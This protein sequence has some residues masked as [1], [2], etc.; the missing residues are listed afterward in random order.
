M[1]GKTKNLDYS[2]VPTT[3]ELE[4][5]GNQSKYTVNRKPSSGITLSKLTI[6][7]MAL[8]ALLLIALAVGLT[9]L[10]Y[11]H[12]STAAPE[13]LT[14]A[15]RPTATRLPTNLSPSH[16]RLQI[17]PFLNEKNFTT[18]GAVTITFKVKEETN[19]IVVNIYDMEIDKESVKVKHINSTEYIT[20]TD[21][22]FEDVSQIYVI[23]TQ[24]VLQNDEEY[25]L[26]IKFT[27]HLRDNMQGF[28]RSQYI[29]PK[30]N[31]N[32]YMA[33]TQFSPID[34]RRAFPCFDEPSFKAKFTISVGRPS[35]M[36]S[37]SNMPKRSTDTMY[38]DLTAYRYNNSSRTL[39]T[40]HTRMKSADQIKLAIDLSPKI[41][42][43]Y[44]NYFKIKFPLPKIDLVGV[45]DF[46]FNAMEN[47]GLITF[48]ETAILFDENSA[49]IEDKK[50]IITVLAH[51]IAHQW[52]GNLVTPAWWNDLWL[53][54]GFSNFMLYYAIQQIYPTW[55]FMDEY[56]LNENYEAFKFDYYKSSRPV[57]LE[58]VNA[59][60]IRQMFDSISY[61]KGASVI[62]MLSHIVGQEVFK[63]GLIQYLNQY[64]YSNANHDQLWTA[65]ETN[66]EDSNSLDVS[67]KEV[68]DSWILQPGFPVVTAVRNSTTGEV[69]LSQKRFLFSKEP[70]NKTLWWIPVSYASDLKP[71]LD[72]TKPKFWIRNVPEAMVV[73][74]ANHWWLLNVQQTGYYIVNYDENN[75]RRLTENIII[76]PPTTR[77]QLI[78]DSMDLARANLLDYDIPLKMLTNLA[79]Q[80]KDISF[81]THQAALNKVSFLY[82]ML[83][84]SPIFKQFEDFIYRIFNNAFNKVD[85]NDLPYDEYLV[86]RIRKLITKWACTK[87]ESKCTNTAQLLFRKWIDNPIKDKLRP[88]IQEV[89]YCTSIREG[90]ETEWDF[91]YNFYI[92]STS[93]YEKNI[94]LDSLGCSQKP[95]ILNRY[96]DYILNNNTYIRK[97]DSSRVFK[98]VANNPVGNSLA[99]SYLRRNW[100]ELNDHFGSAFSIVSKMVAELPR[101]MNNRYQLAEL[102]NFKN[103]NIDNLGTSSQALDR[104]IETVKSNIEWMDHSYKSIENWLNDQA[105]YYGLQK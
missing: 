9:I 63:Q 86:Q 23:T 92:K 73:I 13:A 99:F 4:S 72:N 95:W 12:C 105:R 2:S 50:Q 20:V 7:L 62:R 94:L 46:G 48:R 14:N 82:N 64:Q 1:V 89:V 85:F 93:I 78:S 32:R 69:H 81:V 5:N 88:N 40:V 90:G 37:I 39:F 17:I 8:G 36:S 18:S 91:L 54:E 35:N 6:V 68:M 61:S 30:T 77:V 22:Q 43:F 27:G 44:E 47:W 53:K 83:G 3:A 25:D 96:L 51:E 16:Y 33:S 104:V 11:P 74:E 38:D 19:K 10:L 71:H 66:I 29:D 101:Y 67:I 75:W 49:T 59:D 100:K 56:V 97:Q 60:N 26:E 28:Y 24:D 41:L 45:P 52:F 57:T 34:A 15:V 80:D 84:S 42:E 65:V 79:I 103:E 98:A 31:T 87:S 55:N 102:E 70:A 21:Q 76:F 58:V